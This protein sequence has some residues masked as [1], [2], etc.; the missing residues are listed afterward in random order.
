MYA[1]LCRF[2]DLRRHLEGADPLWPE[3]KKKSIKFQ[4]HWGN[5]VSLKCKIFD[6]FCK[7]E[8][9]SRD[10]VVKGHLIEKTKFIRFYTNRHAV[11]SITIMV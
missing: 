10:W 5:M 2:T 9:V 7:V 4:F 11:R 3:N 8:A 6:F 1:S